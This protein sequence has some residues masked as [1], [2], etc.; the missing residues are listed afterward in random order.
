[1]S[2]PRMKW[3]RAVTPTLAVIATVSLTATPALAAP[4]APGAKPG[5]CPPGLT[6]SATLSPAQ[7][8]GVDLTGCD[9]EATVV[10]DGVG[11]ELPAPGTGVA[12]F[13]V[14]S[15]GEEAS[16]IV[17]TDAA[18]RVDVRV[19]GQAA[20]TKATSAAAVTRCTDASYAL[21]GAKWYSTPTYRVNSAER[22]PSNITASRWNAIATAAVGTLKTGKNTCGL[23]AIHAP[24]T[25]ATGSGTDANITTANACATPDT[26]STVDFGSLSGSLLG[27]TCVAFT[28]RSGHDQI[29][30][31][32]TR[33]DNSSRAWVYT[34]TGCSGARYDLLST[35][36][37]E[38]GHAYGLNHAVERGG[39]DLMMSPV[40]TS[41]NA[42]S[43]TLGRGDLAGM[44]ALYPR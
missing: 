17:T 6:Q 24:G 35:T 16:L 39:S 3:S 22:R 28:V 18:G 37:H 36:T 34:T 4:G 38:I 11:V 1:M 20:T 42:S 19:E 2:F 44:V 41:C 31:A 27:L 5:V 26:Y 9:T 32:D 40:I 8:R 30:A 29:V 25:V 23:A 7:A 12:A 10:V 15:D 43:R 21:M 33:I 14:R 13:G